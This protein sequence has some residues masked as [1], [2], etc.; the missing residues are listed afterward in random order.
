ML[1]TYAFRYH[2][3]NKCSEK[4]RGDMSYIQNLTKRPA[5]QA[6]AGT[7][8]PCPRNTPYPFPYVD[9][10]YEY[11]KFLDPTQPIASFPTDAYP[12]AKVAVIGAGAGGMVAAYEL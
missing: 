5:A 11:T 7:A 6:L 3:F 4:R 8:Q 1:R 9:T 10:L 2:P 12:V